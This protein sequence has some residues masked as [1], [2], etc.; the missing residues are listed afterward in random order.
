MTESKTSACPW[1]GEEI[2]AVAKKC[3]HCGEF[4]ADKVS[5][6][7]PVAY[8][9]STGMFTGTLLQI[10]R[11][12]VRAVEDLRWTVVSA[13]EGLGLLTFETKMSMG[14]WSGVTCTLSFREEGPSRW[15]V[16]GSGK[17]NV[18]GAQMLAV[19]FGESKRKAN[20]AIEAMQDLAG[21]VDRSGGQPW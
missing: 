5:D 2:L 1:C 19:D 9:P 12:A 3:K 21:G 11:L 4:L 8:D 20:K 16:S 6:E 13:N 18:R 10:Q 17:Q 14:S 15:R 7:K